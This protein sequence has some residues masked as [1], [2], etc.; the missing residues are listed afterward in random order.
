MTEKKKWGRSFR[1]SVVCAAAGALVLAASPVHAGSVT[2]ENP[3]QAEDFTTLVTNFLQWLLGIAGGVALLMLIYGGIMYITS[4]G[5]QQ[6]AETGKKIVM[7]TLLGLLV[8]LLSFSIV[9]VMEDI[10]VN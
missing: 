7:Y 8:V 10:F 3:I 2:I 5:D 9:K 1:A 4:A 6:K